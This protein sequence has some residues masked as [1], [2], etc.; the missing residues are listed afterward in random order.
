MTLGAICSSS[1]GHFPLK[2]YSNIM[3]P[4]TLRPGLDKLPT[5]PAP[6]G[7]ITTVNTIGTVRV[8]STKGGIAALPIAR[9]T[10]DPATNSAAFFLPAAVN[11]ALPRMS[12]CTSRPSTQPNR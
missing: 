8:A 3:K 2:L 7:S 9:T 1:S 10:S 5:K 6:T 12:N 11:P 4:V